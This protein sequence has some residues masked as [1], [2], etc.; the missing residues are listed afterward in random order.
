MTDECNIFSPAVLVCTT[1]VTV[2]PVTSNRQTAHGGAQ[3]FERW[4]MATAHPEAAPGALELVRL[5][6]PLLPAE[7]GGDRGGKFG[8]PSLVVGWRGR[9]GLSARD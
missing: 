3:D 8:H 6:L 9:A 7:L 1:S 4:G 2:L 5:D